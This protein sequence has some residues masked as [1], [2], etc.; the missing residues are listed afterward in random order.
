[1][2]HTR[3][4]LALESLAQYATAQYQAIR[5]KGKKSWEEIVTSWPPLE[6]SCSGSIKASYANKITNM[7]ILLFKKNNPIGSIQW[8]I[9]HKKEGDEISPWNYDVS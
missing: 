3:H 5:K 9:R 7:R 6:G 1:M 2:V 8:S 4:I